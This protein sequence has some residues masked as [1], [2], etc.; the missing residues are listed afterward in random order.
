MK[1]WGQTI[2][3]VLFAAAM[4]GAGRSAGFE[5]MLIVCGAGFVAFIV[6]RILS[7]I[8]TRILSR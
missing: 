7:G 6:F 5:G 2:V 8:V 1:D 3:M 4:I